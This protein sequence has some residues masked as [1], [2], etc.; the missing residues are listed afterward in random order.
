MNAGYPQQDRPC[1]LWQPRIEGFIDG[2]LSPSDADLV[3]EHLR[4]CAVCRAEAQVLAE[5]SQR[6]RGLATEVAPASLWER[7]DAG[8]EEPARH[9]DLPPAASNSSRPLSRRSALALAASAAVVVASGAYF[10]LPNG[11]SV[12]TASVN[13]FI[14]YR[15]R[16][17][18]VDLAARDAN[19]LSAWAQ[20]RVSF[21]VPALKERFGTFEIGG[22]RLCWLLN[23]R[24]LGLTYAS[25][26]DRAVVY[27]MEAQGLILPTADQS[28][29]DGRRAAVQHVK[30]HGV[31]VWS[32]N[33]LVFVLVAGEK[34]FSRALQ[35]AGRR[36]DSGGRV[37]RTRGDTT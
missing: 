9:S 32:E 30:G 2:E 17:W 12:V 21:A 26:E 28:L 11:N 16:G 4:T 18:T 29:P 23:R 3:R 27:V 33:D 1:R 20:A 8:L 34:D 5:L 13:D 24:L 35:V 10:A 6:M 19:A 7:I 15:A 22:V 37:S 14:T 36:A 31:A 25:G